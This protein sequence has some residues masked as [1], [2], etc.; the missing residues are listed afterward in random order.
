MS[1][2]GVSGER[3]PGAPCPPSPALVLPAVKSRLRAAPRAAPQLPS[4]TASFQHRGQRPRLPPDPAKSPQPRARRPDSGRDSR[5]CEAGPP[6]ASTRVW[7]RRLGCIRTSA[8]P[9]PWL[10]KVIRGEGRAAAGSPSRP[11]PF[12]VLPLGPVFPSLTS[13][14]QYRLSQSPSSVSFSSTLGSLSLSL[15]S[16]PTPTPFS[17]WPCFHDICLQP[18][19][20]QELS[21]REG[22]RLSVRPLG[23]TP[24][25]QQP[26]KRNKIAPQ[27]LIWVGA[28]LRWS[29]LVNRPPNESTQ[30]ALGPPLRTEE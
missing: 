13:A 16:P 24:W 20:E 29:T 21:Q 22:L 7:A 23:D 25:G 30:E 4:G 1:E 14:S 18:R 28:V 17:P 11:S 10:A 8:G 19:P 5:P 27:H 9:T 26:G 2:R 15:P 6:G 12:S 3:A